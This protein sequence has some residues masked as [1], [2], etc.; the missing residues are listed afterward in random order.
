M[1]RQ[2]VFD[3]LPKVDFGAGPWRRSVAPDEL[4]IETDFCAF[5]DGEKSCLPQSR[6]RANIMKILFC[7]ITDSRGE[8]GIDFAIMVLQ[9]PFAFAF[10]RL[11]LV[12]ATSAKEAFAEFQKSD[13]DC[14]VCC[15]TNRASMDFLVRALSARDKHVI[16]G[17]EPVPKVDWDRVAAGQSATVFNIVPENLKLHTRGDGFC[18]LKKVYDFSTTF[19]SIFVYKKCDTAKANRQNM[20]VDLQCPFSSTAKVEFAGCVK[21]RF[22]QPLPTTPTPAAETTPT[23]EPTTAA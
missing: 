4:M 8:C 3:K 13:F 23:A 9:L 18:Q 21:Y 12:Y 14:I 2:G 10:E 16:V 1:T 11:H 19:P 15:P 7:G 5:G 6:G 22:L 17:M 20:W